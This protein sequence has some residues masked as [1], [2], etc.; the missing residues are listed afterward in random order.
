MRNDFLPATAEEMRAQGWDAPDFVFVTGDAY[1]DHPSFGCAILTRVL[2]SKGYRVCV[3]PQPDWHT[4]QDFTRF[5]R[6]R[7]GFLVSAGVIDSMVNRYTV[8]KR[9]RERDVYSPGGKAGCRPDRATIAY[10][11]RIREAYGGIPIVIGGIEASLRRFAHYDYWENAVRRSILFDS[12]AD[13][14]LFGMGENAIVETAALLEREDFREGLPELRGA[15]FLSRQAPEGYELLPSYEEV[16]ADKRAY[17]RAFLRQYAAQDAFCGKPLA[18]AHADRYLCQNLPAFPLARQELDAVYDLP[19]CR[20]WHPM[21]DAQGG[22]PALEEVKFSISATRGCF[23]CCSFCALSFHQG[24]C[25]SSRSLRSILKEAERLTHM[26]DFK[27]YIHD[28]GGPTANFRRPACRKQ[29]TEGACAGRQCLFPQPCKNL[30]PDH[31]ELLSI[32]RRAR[33]L[34]GVKKV[35]IRSGLRYDYILLDKGS[36]FLQELLEHHVSGHLKV[37]P[38]HVD[39]RVLSLM[40]KPPMEV[41]ERF[42][43]RCREINDRLGRKQ[44]LLPYFISSHPGSDMT[45]AVALAEYLRDT[46]Q[47]PEQ[48]QDFYPTPGTLSTCMFYTGLDP[49]TME[50][51]YVPNAPHEKAMQRALLQYR[52]RQ[53]W[54]LV[55]QALRVAGRED[56]IG[57]GGK[58]LVPPEGEAPRRKGDAQGRQQR[59]GRDKQKEKA[60]GKHEKTAGKHSSPRR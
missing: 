46:R 34:P 9:P 1:V 19:Y 26:P 13:I 23:G 18:Q 41:Y 5:G 47:Q 48:V 12:G 31:T 32:L 42:A 59:A 38:E 17:A 56:L 10:C 25:V 2:Q 4:A 39:P 8:A 43:R 37:A 28:I 58:C 27:G 60:H 6:P 52:R 51:V 45:A 40:G 55:R 35:F 3:L 33:A 54:P 30:R 24:R 7:L 53:N 57:Y 21:Y 15:C 11:N 50:A 49:R 16:A 29:A 20:T 22:V 14:L 36:P 44:Y